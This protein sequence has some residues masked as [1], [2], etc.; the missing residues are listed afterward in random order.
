MPFGPVRYERLCK[1]HPRLSLPRIKIL[2][3]LYRGGR[4]LLDDDS[5]MNVVFPQY[6][7]EGPNVYGER[8]ARAYYENMM[9]LV[10][11]QISAGLA[12][13]P[14]RWQT[15]TDGTEEKDP[16]AEGYWAE[17]LEDATAISDDQSSCR[18]LDQVIRDQVV[19]ALVCGWSWLQADLPY[20]DQIQFS[21]LAE[22]TAAGG[23]RAYLVPWPTEC[24]LDWE[25]KAGRL[26]WVRTYRCE[27]PA[28]D[29]TRDRDVTRHCYTIWGPEDWTEYEILVSND[30]RDESVGAVIGGKTVRQQLPGAKELISPSST[31]GHSFGRV[32]F[33]RMDLCSGGGSQLHVGDLIESLIRAYFNR[34]NG[35]SFQWTQF[36]YQQLYEFLGPEMSGVDDMVSDAQKD[37]S[38]ARRRRS[39]GTIHVRGA[40]DKAEFVSPNMQGADVGREALQ[41]L[42]DAIL[43]VTAQM[44]LAQDTSG[45]MLRRSADS[46]RQDSVAQ[47]I[48]LGAIGKRALAA[49]EAAVQLLA[50]GVNDEQPPDVAGYER[51]DVADPES[52][53]SMDA[54]LEQINIPSARFQIERK[55][56]LAM[57]RLGDNVK[58][59]HRAEIRQQLEAQITQDQF[60]MP[61]P[62]EQFEAAQAQEPDADDEGG[63]S[64]G[65]DREPKP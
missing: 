65:N 50:A 5:V 10:V 35:E 60:E 30:R 32:P 46:K 8:K 57:L 37:P 52:M 20:G 42:R 49:T 44:A 53:V 2:K 45:A 9:A 59:E 56:D 27:L 22:Q 55:F 33:V 36:N 51:F 48:V 47:E 39:P 25:E 13:D 7:Y 31:G 40:D 16:Y 17:I 63:E 64:D 1:T 14:I 41:D 4:A 6:T 24:V 61:T 62:M 26:L 34:V 38:R 18:G 11:N 15:I 3:A 23:L 58:P 28:D 12:Q 29:P 21:S 54:L 19:E 43:R